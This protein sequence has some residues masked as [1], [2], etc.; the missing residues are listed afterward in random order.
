MNKTELSTQPYKG[1]VDMYPE[2]ILARNYLFDTWKK[3]A[4]EFGYE[5]YD[6]PILEDANLYRVKS[7]EELAGKQLFSFTDRAGREV[8]LRPEM[9][10]S[11][12][13]IISRKRKELTLPIRWFNIGR[14]YRYEKPQRGRTREF[15]QLNIDILGIEGI[16]AEIEIIQFVMKVMKELKAK[17]GT[18]ELRINNRYLFDYLTENILKIDNETKSVLGRAVD[19][20]LKIDKS[21]F[22]EYLA[23]IGL[24]G[25]QRESVYEYLN[26][27]LKDLEEIKD[28]S[29]GAREL[30]QLFELAKNLG[31]E[32]I[33]F[34]PYIMRGLAY[35]TGTVMEMFDI[36]SKENPRALFG[37]GRYDDLLDIFNQE[38]LPAFGLGWGDVTTLDYLKTYSVIP[39]AKTETKV[40]VTLMGS[41]LF[42]QT[43]LLAEYLRENGINTQMQ[44]TS[45]KLGK[46]LQYADK[47]SIPWVIIMGEDEL[48]ENIVQLKD[49]QS[50]KTFRIKKEDI[51]DKIK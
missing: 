43:S 10:P 39:S 34:T 13:R 35:Y 15:A 25:D 3:V 49:M 8:S 37:G 19:N 2:D 26:W 30:L 51:I 23:E 4:L 6:T 14:F 47:K 22:N 50:K 32:N 7:G 12:A 11:L 44:L 20:Y 17:K 27:D 45:V 24:S 16:E 46:Q 9:T 33:R 42:T 48:K 28:S 40:F 41:S 36:G 5:E 1:T 21:D 29:R 38:K 31:I 18:Y